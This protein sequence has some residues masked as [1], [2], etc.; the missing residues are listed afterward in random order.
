MPNVRSPSHCLDIVWFRLMLLATN[1]TLISS[2]R[3]P[4]EMWSLRI[5]VGLSLLVHFEN[6]QVGSRSG[7][8][9]ETLGWRC[10]S[11]RDGTNGI[12][13]LK[14]LLLRC[15][16]FFLFFP[17]PFH[18]SLLLS[19]SQSCLGFGSRDS[20]TSPFQPGTA[21]IYPPCEHARIRPQTE[22]LHPSSVLWFKY[23]DFPQRLRYWE[24]VACYGLDLKRTSHH[25]SC[26]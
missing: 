7:S 5:F 26:I 10:G 14:R 12:H 25:V 13:G 23:K 16:E 22:W 3:K 1:R 18:T 17:L 6:H 24:W 8:R 2:P 21:Q 15:T 11:S 9:P 20:Y 19:L 4:G